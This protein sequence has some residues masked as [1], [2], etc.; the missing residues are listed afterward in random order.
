MF[1]FVAVWDI[2]SP[3]RCS[4]FVLECEGWWFCRAHTHHMASF[5]RGT[6]P[7]VPRKMAKNVHLKHMDHTHTAGSLAHTC[8]LWLTPRLQPGETLV[9]VC[10]SMCYRCKHMELC[11]LKYIHKPHKFVCAHTSPCRG[12]PSVGEDCVC[13][14]ELEH[15]WRELL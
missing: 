7:G 9:C 13:A 6:Q 4:V 1:S 11:T 10:V 14:H 8:W 12:V 3:K 15:T 5:N 2:P